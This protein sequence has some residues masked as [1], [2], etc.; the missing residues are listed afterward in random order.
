MAGAEEQVARVPYAWGLEVRAD[1]PGRGPSARRAGQ[2]PRA[3]ASSSSSE[4]EWTRWWAES[5]CREAPWSSASRRAS[6]KRQTA[7]AA[8][9]RPRRPRKMIRI[10]DRDI[11]WSRARSTPPPPGSDAG[12]RRLSPRPKNKRAELVAV[13]ARRATTSRRGLVRDAP[14]GSML[15]RARRARAFASLPSAAELERPRRPLVDEI[16]VQSDRP[17]RRPDRRLEREERVSVSTFR[18]VERPGD[19]RRSALR[20]PSPS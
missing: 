2:S 15:A 5:R 1:E 13:S 4:T 9:I 20:I 19:A 3:S 10:V 12:E 16:H 14:T 11:S 17:H 18:V 8:G 6:S 7:A